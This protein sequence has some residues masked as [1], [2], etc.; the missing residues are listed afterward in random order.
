MSFFKHIKQHMTIKKLF[1]H[2]EKGVTNQIILAMIASLLTY[3][4][5]VE[6]GSKKTPFQIKRLLKH[7]L[8]QPFEEWL[9]LLI[10]T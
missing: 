9:A 8:F 7:L 10:P 1:S 5:K 6:T 2:S 3:L 4:I